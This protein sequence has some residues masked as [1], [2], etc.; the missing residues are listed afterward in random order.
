MGISMAEQLTHNF[1]DYYSHSNE[2]LIITFNFSALYKVVLVLSIL[3]IKHKHT[4]WNKSNIA[5]SG[6]GLHANYSCLFINP[7]VHQFI[8]HNYNIQVQLVGALGYYISIC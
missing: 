3:H 7:A 6:R 4:M 8:L 1:I 5:T 2:A